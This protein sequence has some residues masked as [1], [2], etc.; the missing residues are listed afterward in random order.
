MIRAPAPSRAYAPC[1]SAAALNDI[2][3]TLNRAGDDDEALPVLREALAMQRA[4]EADG[5]V[6]GGAD[7]HVFDEIAGIDAAR[8]DVERA[9][10][11]RALATRA[12]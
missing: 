11:C 9:A 10:R 2:G 5:A 6:A 8:G 1:W 4:L 7:P 12:R 3:V